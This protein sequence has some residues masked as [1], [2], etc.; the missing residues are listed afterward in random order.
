MSTLFTIIAIIF[1]LSIS[2]IR[3]SSAQ[4]FATCSD[5]YLTDPHPISL[6]GQQ[7]PFTINGRPDVTCAFIV[8]VANQ[9]NTVFVGQLFES[10][11]FDNGKSIAA[12]FGQKQWNANYPAN[13]D[14][15]SGFKNTQYRWSKNRMLDMHDNIT[16]TYGPSTAQLF[17]SCNFD[18]SMRRDYLHMTFPKDF[19]NLATL[20]SGSCYSIYSADIRGHFCENGTA[21]FEYGIAEHFWLNS[22]LGGPCTCTPWQPSSISSEA[23]FGY[24]ILSLS[25]FLFVICV[26]SCTGC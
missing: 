1:F 10:T 16:L 21:A 4:S 14:Q 2:H 24:R 18:F 8:D 3:Q 6:H 25:F 17:I 13:E 23:S 19:I 20:N 12:T 7:L 5:V 22:N 26:R 15:S 9:G 11:S